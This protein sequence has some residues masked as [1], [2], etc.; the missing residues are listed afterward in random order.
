MGSITFFG[1]FHIGTGTD[2]TDFFLPLAIGHLS[3][4]VLKVCDLSTISQRPYLLGSSTLGHLFSNPWMKFKNL[5]PFVFLNREKI[6]VRCELSSRNVTDPIFKISSHRHKKFDNWISW[7]FLITIINN[8][9][10]FEKI[11]CNFVFASFRKLSIFVHFE[12][13]SSKLIWSLLGFYWYVCKV[14]VVILKLALS[15]L[16]WV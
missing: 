13:S 6:F 1:E 7:S 11:L 14:W 5:L 8:C 12:F 10:V 4:R 9:G 3:C 15:A 16:K 2:H